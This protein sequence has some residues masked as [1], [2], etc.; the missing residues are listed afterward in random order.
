M[1]SDLSD[2]RKKKEEEMTKERR[3]AV[4]EQKPRK[5]PLSYRERNDGKNRKNW[6][7]RGYDL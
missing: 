3:R 2:L 5:A 1:E 7:K 4:E 6:T